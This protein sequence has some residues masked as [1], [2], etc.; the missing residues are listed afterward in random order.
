MNECNSYGAIDKKKLTN[1]IKFSL[2]EISQN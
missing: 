1:Q 2:D